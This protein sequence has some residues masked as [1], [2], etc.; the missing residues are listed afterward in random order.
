M[1]FTD[2]FGLAASREHG[3]PERLNQ[4]ILGPKCGTDPCV[5]G[6]PALTRFY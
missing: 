5:T 1:N 2:W 6:I 3:L 4:L